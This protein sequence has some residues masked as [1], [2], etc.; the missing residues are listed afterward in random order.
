MLKLKIGLLIGGAI[1]WAVGS[2][3]ARQ[4]WQ[5]LRA[6]MGDRPG[7][8]TQSW[9]DEAFGTEPRPAT[10][11]GVQVTETVISSV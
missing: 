10:G 11:N 1:G 3:R 4:W 6:S 7:T 9:A 8:G 5:S 2:G